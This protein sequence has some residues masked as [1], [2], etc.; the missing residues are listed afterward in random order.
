MMKSNKGA[1][2]GGHA[3]DLAARSD[4]WDACRSSLAQPAGV[5]RGVVLNATGGE[6][7]LS[8]ELGVVDDQFAVLKAVQ[9]RDV[10]HGVVLPVTVNNQGG[11]KGAQSPGV[12][13]VGHAGDAAHLLCR[14]ER[15]IHL[16]LHAHPGQQLGDLK[17]RAHRVHPDVVHV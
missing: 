1:S 2:I 12:G 10:V 15:V 17:R 16:H 4:P 11:V 7:H 5:S 13:E 3:T 6:V 9:Q 8:P 14:L